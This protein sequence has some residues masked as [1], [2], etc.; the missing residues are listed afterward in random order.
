MRA[1]C[2]QV[3]EGEG[4]SR[5]AEVGITIP[6]EKTGLDTVERPTTR[7]VRMTCAHSV[8]TDSRDESSKAGD[9]V[10]VGVDD[11][12]ATQL[13]LCERSRRVYAH[14]GADGLEDALAGLIREACVESEGV[15]GEMIDELT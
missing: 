2:A 7:E 6:I 13:E 14:G 5:T 11:A 9:A 10:L 15:A 1:D 3:V 12:D 4:A 8:V